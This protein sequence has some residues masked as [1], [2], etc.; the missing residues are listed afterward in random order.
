MKR[1]IAI[2]WN[3]IATFAAEKR[4]SMKKSIVVLLFASVLQARA[5]LT[6]SII[7][8][9][10]LQD[11]EIVAPI[12]ENGGMRQQT[13]SVTMIDQK[14]MDANHITSLKASSNIVPN[15]FIPDYGSRLTSAIYIRGVGSRINTPAVGLYVDDV[16]YVDK[17]TF[18]FNFYDIE[19]IDVLRG[20]QGTLYG[21]NTMGGLIK[22]YTKNPFNY[23]G[24][25]IKLGYAIGDN[26]RNMSLTHYHRIS[27]K[28]AFA[29]GAYYEGA[30]GFFENDISGKKVDYMKSGGA[31]VRGLYKPNSRLTLDLSVNY[32]Y[33]SEG[34]YPYFYTG[35]LTGTEQYAQFI[36]KIS[37]NRES[38]YRRGLLDT[39]LNIG[40]EAENW[41]M[42]AVTGFQNVRDR[43]FMDQDFLQPDIYTL[44]Q[45][46]HINTLNEEI[47]FKNKGNDKWEWVS[48]MNLM[49][50]ALQTEAPVVFY[51]D[52]LQW[53]EGNINRMLPTMDKI[54]ML[55]GM[56]FSG[57][58]IDFKGEQLNIESTFKTPTLGAALF[59][60]ST[61]HFNNHLSATLGVRL[62]FEH[63][64]MDYDSP[65]LVDYAFAMPNS[66]N[67]MMSVALN[68][69]Q[70]D[71]R[72][73]GTMRNNRLSVLPKFALKYAFDKDNSVYASVSL[74]QR[75]GGYNLQ[76]FSDLTQGALRV[77]MM[78]GIKNGVGDYIDFLTTVNDKIPNV[79]PDPENPGS[80]I[81]LSDYVRR[82]MGNSMPKF[83]TPTTAQVAYK[84][85]HSWN[86]EAGTHLTLAERKLTLDA[87]IFYSNIYNQQIARFVPSGLGRMMVN[88]GKSESYGGELELRYAPNRNLHLGANYGFTHA[89]FMDYEDGNGNDYAGNRVPFVPMHTANIDA[90][91]T[92]FTESGARAGQ[93]QSADNGKWVKSITLGANC[94]GTGNLYW[95]ESN[96]AKQSFYA[97]LGAR[98]TMEAKK[99]TMTLWGKNLTN[100]K[101]NTFFF[102]SAG[103]GFE[104]HGKPLQ[105]GLD[106]KLH[107]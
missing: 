30:S 17:S 13:A 10:Q 64:K 81:S 80:M 9:T 19:R 69:L 65:T 71:I 104:Q 87:S 15:I 100:A 47:T 34:A 74:G 24:T 16:P 55:M 61:Y 46:Q 60:Q 43:M 97:L 41:K 93:W 86:Y 3:N 38:L 91:Y 31:R 79:I 70:S 88:A 56:G 29:G 95:T 42:N 68:D 59:H 73:S 90:A 2:D 94:S 54:P 40:Y 51:Q 28:L 89:T 7:N 12:K 39:K 11:I 1:E 25:D 106:V 33:S 75:S 20:P 72:Y 52:G 63:K 21:N 92:W 44:E 84:P 85:E 98:L 14:Q 8:T 5:E 22:V 36:G 99:V 23:E 32:D 58:S 82:T 6:D 67:P 96:N 26:H 107:F 50:Q 57:M 102:E 76:M 83:E 45:K 77:D 4:K 49:Y 101:Y 35:S 105:I 78:E 53:L 18:D 66:K 103:R 62:D 48:G 27:Q 37:S